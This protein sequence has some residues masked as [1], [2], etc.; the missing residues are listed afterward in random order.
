MASDHQ[1]IS[2]ASVEHFRPES[3]AQLM[4]DGLYYSSQWHTKLVKKRLLKSKKNLITP[5]L[6]F[7]QD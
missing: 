4:A 1:I 3:R 7:P 2:T 6:A 5:P